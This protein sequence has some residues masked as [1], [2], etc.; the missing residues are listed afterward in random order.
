MRDRD[1]ADRLLQPYE[2]DFKNWNAANNATT[3]AGKA[4]KGITS[5][6]LK[7]MLLKV[8]KDARAK[9]GRGPI[10]FLHEQAPAYQGVAKDK[11]LQAAFAGGVEI[12]AGR[13]PDLSHLDAGV[14]KTMEQAVER[15]GASTAD[16][17]REVVQRTWNEKTTDEYCVRISKRVRKNM[18]EVIE[19]KGGNFYQD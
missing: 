16:E 4:A 14:C 15:E 11:Q 10:R 1:E 18:L 17:I 3:K 2:L 5:A 19:R 12:A 7:P 8:A 6:Y 9:L 13:A